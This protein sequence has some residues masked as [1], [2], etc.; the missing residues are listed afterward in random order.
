MLSYRLSV[1]MM[2]VGLLLAGTLYADRISYIQGSGAKAEM[3]MDED[4]TIT[5]WSASKVDYKTADGKAASVKY[6]DILSLD[7][8]Y[9][10]MS[11]QLSE[12]MDLIAAD[13]G[14]AIAALAEIAANGNALDREEAAFLRANILDSESYADKALLGQAVKAYQDYVKSYKAGYF[15]REVYRGLS[16]GQLRSNDVSGARATLKGMVRADSALEREGNQLLGELEAGEAKWSDAIAAFKAA[17]SSASSE[18]DKNH[19]YLAKAWEGWCTLKNGNAAAAKTLLESVTDDDGFDDPN[20][21]VDEAAL[22]VAYPALGDCYFEGD[23]FQKA[24]DAYVKGAYFAWWSAGTREGYCLGQAY[25]C[26]KKN[27][28]TGDKWKKRMTKLRTAL[29]LGF[30]RVLAEVDKQ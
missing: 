13:P 16:N 27:E 4:I 2:A 22:G 17:Q 25:L 28:S 23:N 12:A 29:A 11:A 1:A 19:E 20:S 5:G 8:H 14:D 15:A 6:N 7:R 9:G 21:T 30:P 10:S 26:A 3:K 24:Y 18:K